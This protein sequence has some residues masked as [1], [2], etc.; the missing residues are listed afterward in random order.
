MTKNGV[1][2]FELLGCGVLRLARKD[3]DEESSTVPHST[4]TEA[5]ANELYVGDHWTFFAARLPPP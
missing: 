5:N 2:K 4:Q 1:A 3:H